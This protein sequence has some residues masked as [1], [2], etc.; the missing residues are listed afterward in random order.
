M[1]VVD[2]DD[3]SQTTTM[4]NAGKN[5]LGNSSFDSAF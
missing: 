2:A 4:S 3:L 5:E 1:G